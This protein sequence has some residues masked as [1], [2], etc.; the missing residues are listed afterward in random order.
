[1]SCWGLC[2]KL[3]SK[4]CM[5]K[6]DTGL[7]SATVHR[8]L[9]TTLHKYIYGKR[10]KS[11][12]EN[13]GYDIH[14]L[15]ILHFFSIL[16]QMTF[17][18]RHFPSGRIPWIIVTLYPCFTFLQRSY[19]GETAVILMLQASAKSSLSD[20]ERSKIRLGTHEATKF[21]AVPGTSPIQ[22]CENGKTP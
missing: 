3:D 17:E 10:E 9:V 4:Q 16:W 2:C 15:L 7:I 6:L 11:N 8:Q 1:M 21:G 14:P 12:R 5:L 13:L 19:T 22:A 18:V 20:K